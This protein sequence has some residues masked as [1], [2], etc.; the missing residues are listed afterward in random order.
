MAITHLSDHKQWIEEGTVFGIIEPVTEIKEGDT[1]VAVATAGA[2]KKARRIG[3]G[4]IP[5][6][7]EKIRKVLVEYGDYFSWLGDQL[8]LCTAAE[9]TIEAGGKDI[10]DREAE[11]RE[12]I[13]L[14]EEVRRSTRA[15]MPPVRYGQMPQVAVGALLFL[16]GLLGPRMGELFPPTQLRS[17]DDSVDDSEREKR[18]AEHHTYPFELWGVG[19]A[20][21]MASVA[22]CSILWCCGRKGDVNM[23]ELRERLRIVEE[24][25][26]EEIKKRRVWRWS[27]MHCLTEIDNRM[28][29]HEETCLTTLRD[30]E[31]SIEHLA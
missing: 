8:G 9:Q 21:F 18:A 26:E 3:E 11:T 14:D 10:R 19:A 24:F 25:V 6:D 12:T 5:T 27:T 17:L 4:L 15:R 20:L 16:L 30:L 1:P 28:T 22:V 13:P 29:A 23:A 31:S 2:E 7:R